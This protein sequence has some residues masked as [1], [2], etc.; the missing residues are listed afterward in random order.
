MRADAIALLRYDLHA[1]HGDA[2]FSHGAEK[3]LYAMSIGSR[4]VTL[5]PETTLSTETLP[6]YLTRV[7]SLSLLWCFFLLARWEYS[8]ESFDKVALSRGGSN[9]V[10]V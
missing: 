1:L 10:L 6:H 4:A 9:T 5:T 2:Q 8:E 7:P 3:T